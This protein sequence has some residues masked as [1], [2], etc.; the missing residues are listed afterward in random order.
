MDKT[1]ADSFPASDR[2]RPAELA[3]LSQAVRS[4]FFAERNYMA[5]PDI[6]G[7]FDCEESL[8][9][10]EDQGTSYPWITSS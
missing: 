8:K 9:T 3:L 10:F 7:E 2:G 1:L 5:A 6:A 4:E